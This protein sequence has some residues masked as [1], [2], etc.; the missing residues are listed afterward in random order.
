MAE[1]LDGRRMA[2][3]IHEA[4]RRDSR[5]R[6]EGITVQME[7]GVATITGTVRSYRDRMLAAEDAW[8]IQGVQEVR[9]RLRVRPDTLRAAEKIAAEVAGA[10]DRQLGGNARSIVVNVAEGAV[11]LSGVV[12]NQKEWAAAE[13]CAWQVQG[14]VD[15]SN[16]LTLSTDRRRP[17]GEI[18]QDVRAALD[19]D[20]GLADSTKITVMCVAGTIRLDGTVSSA[21]ERQAAEKDAWYTAGVVYVEN[22]L[23]IEGE[24]RRTAAA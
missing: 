18:E 6:S 8:G 23:A 7:D 13:E 19:I 21:D 3:R 2:A 4:F 17:D 12:A 24:R 20:A 14:V 11:R 15:V 9:N 10:L 22:M 16:D 1:A 5:L